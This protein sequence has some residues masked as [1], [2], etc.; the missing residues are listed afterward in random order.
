MKDIDAIARVLAEE[1]VKEFPDYR[2]VYFYGSRARGD[3]QVGS[4]Y[5]RAFIFE[6]KP[7]W[8]EKQ[9]ARDTIYLKELDLGIV[10]D[11]HFYSREEIENSAT[12]F[13]E[14]VRNEGAFYAVDC[15]ASVS[16]RV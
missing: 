9:R 6:H 1:L 2:G 8:R 10:I 4:D 11:S 3:E 7:D 14:T 13:R 5:D 15:D 12:S 16:Y